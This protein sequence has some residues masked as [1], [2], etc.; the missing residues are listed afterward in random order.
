MAFRSR[1]MRVAYTL[2]NREMWITWTPLIRQSSPKTKKNGK[3]KPPSLS[4]RPSMYVEH[5]TTGE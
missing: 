4:G 3:N 5:A 2:D 1:R